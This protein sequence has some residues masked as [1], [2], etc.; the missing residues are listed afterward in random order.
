MTRDPGPLFPPYNQ[1]TVFPCGIVSI[2]INEMVIQQKKGGLDDCEW[3]L[4]YFHLESGIGHYHNLIMKLQTHY[5]LDLRGAVDFPLMVV[6][7]GLK[8]G[9]LYAINTDTLNFP[10]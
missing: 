9:K 10:F 1:H 2:I 7:R 8:K 4:V 5:K 3:S 6:D